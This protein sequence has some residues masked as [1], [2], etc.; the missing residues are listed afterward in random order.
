MQSL[1]MCT[2]IVFILVLVIKLPSRILSV[3]VESVFWV[4]S[5]SDGLYCDSLCNS[6]TLKTII[7]MTTFILQHCLKSKMSFIEVL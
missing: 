7:G 2:S 6:N 3:C 1:Y 5:V 4:H